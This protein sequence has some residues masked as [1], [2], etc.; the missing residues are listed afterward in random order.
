MEEVKSQKCIS[1]LFSK[2]LVTVRELQTSLMTV[3][4]VH[5]K[6]TK[7]HDERLKRVLENLKE[8]E[9]PDT[10]SRKV[11]ISH[12]QA[13]FSVYETDANKQGHWTN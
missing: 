13:A 3:I 4:I 6:T 9:K 12:D 7:E 11:Q 5:G 10:K 2:H 8:L 1:M